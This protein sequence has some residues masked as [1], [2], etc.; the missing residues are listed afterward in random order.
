MSS[1]LSFIGGLGLLLFGLKSVSEA[2]QVLF[3]ER[4]RGRMGNVGATRR[5]QFTTGA[6]ASLIAQSSAAEA[7]MIVS[8]VN[9]GLMSL[10]QAAAV[11]VGANVGATTAGWL[12]ALRLGPAAL[13][14]LGCGAIAHLLARREETRFA[15][16]LA[17][18][19]GMLF[20]ALDWLQ[21][22]YVAL[23]PTALPMW[24]MAP[25]AHGVVALLAAVVAAAAAAA[26][27]QS[28]TALIG[29]AIALAATGA[30]RLDGALALV[31][32]AN[33]GSTFSAHR[34]AAPATADSRRAALLHSLVNGLAAVV[35]LLAFPYWLR[36]IA[37]LGLQPV[38]ADGVLPAA[39]PLQVA[40]AHTLFNLL[41]AGLSLPLLG[42]L[43]AVAPRLVG[44]A[45]RERSGLRYLRPGMV[46]SPA[47]AIEQCRLEVLHMAELAAAAL[48]LTRDLLAD[49]HTEARELRRQILERE[50]ATDVVQHEVTVFMTRV[51]ANTLSVAQGAECRALIRAADEIESIADYCERLANYRRRLVRD[52]V[53]LDDTALHDLQAY[54]DRSIALYDDIVDRIRR[55]ET[56]WLSAIEAKAQYLASEANTLRDANLQRLAAQRIAPAAG[57]FYNDMLVAVRRI[58][59]HSL[60][61]AEAFGG[62]G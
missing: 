38:G 53:V 25:Q 3:G 9:A 44:P 54:L 13:A 51:M 5:S 2:L 43:V 55:R 62:A 58:R 42:P 60:N 6:V 16:A 47:L 36:L 1:A 14:L 18:G 45:Q 35:L 15:G 48:R 52:G 24:L 37:L 23:P 31:V 27:L 56:H 10:P 17:M 28:A 39:S 22:A 29:L 12:L 40:L 33:L 41:L 30:L 19:I 57:I 20:V 32:G 8:F 50:K 59:N 26:L 11:I 34:A 4:L 61:L 49:L 46:E 7:V 21:H